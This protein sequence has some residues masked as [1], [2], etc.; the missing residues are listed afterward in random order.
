MIKLNDK[1]LPFLLKAE[2]NELIIYL[3]INRY[4]TNEESVP[5]DHIQKLT[6]LT[7]SELNFSLN[8]LREKKILISQGNDQ[9]PAFK[10]LIHRISGKIELR[11]ISGKKADAYYLNI[12]SSI[13]ID[14][15]N[16]S[17]NKD[18]YS[19]KINH[20]LAFLSQ[21][22]K[23]SIIALKFKR[24]LKKIK[25]KAE[26]KQA[27]EL[28]NFFADKLSNLHDIDR[29]SDWRHQQLA[30]ARRL[31]K[32]HRLPIKVWKEAISYFL[33][34]EYWQDKLTSLKQIEK[35]IHQYLSHKEKKELSIE[36]EEIL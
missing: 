23:Q 27:E 18:L 24:A 9:K 15:N 20:E 35:N 17:N 19:N 32:I 8:Y 13:Y 30:C 21:E 29:T 11:E 16:N 26:Q 4:L 14:S 3:L 25:R 22:K 10:D 31:F 2:R 34:S 33:D 12:I 36:V 1:I 6:G 5:L 7:D 28:V